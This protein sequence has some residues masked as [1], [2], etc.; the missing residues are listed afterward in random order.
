MPIRSIEIKCRHNDPDL[1]EKLLL[2]YGAR[3]IGT[4]QQTDTYFQTV[5]GRL[6]LR[7]GNIENNLIFYQRIESK[8]LKDSKISLFPVVDSSLKLK[9]IL[10]QCY[11]IDKIVRKE[12]KIFF[13]D[14]LKFHIDQVESL[15]S[16]VEIEAIDESGKMDTLFLKNQC[17]KYIN[18]LQ[19]DRS[20]FIDKS[21][22]DMI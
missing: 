13:I 8:G 6:K 5:N 4:D 19:L 18:L 1:I 7:E 22:S 20:D 14:N 15:G 16:F 11:G 12:R 9:E 17:E 3:C 10:E 21:Y 2:K